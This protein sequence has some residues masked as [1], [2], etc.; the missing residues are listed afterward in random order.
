MLR[1]P[2]S[3]RG[4][5]QDYSHIKKETVFRWSFWYSWCVLF[6][7]IEPSPIKGSSLKNVSSDTEGLVAKSFHS[8]PDW[9]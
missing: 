5:R 8:S 6:P 3:P 4:K 7:A 2:G 9:D 1:I